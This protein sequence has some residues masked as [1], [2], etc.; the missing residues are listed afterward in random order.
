MNPY[1]APLSVGN[2]T[3]PEHLK[4]AA[5]PVQVVLRSVAAYA[6]SPRNQITIRET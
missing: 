3:A 6:H 1:L 5:S 2:I 4:T